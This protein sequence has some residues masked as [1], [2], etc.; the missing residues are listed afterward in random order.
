MRNPF[1]TI[2]KYADGW[3]IFNVFRRS[4]PVATLK[5]ITDGSRLLELMEQEEVMLDYELARQ[6]YARGI[7]I[8][9]QDVELYAIMKRVIEQAEGCDPSIL[10]EQAIAQMRQASFQ[11]IGTPCAVW[12]A[13][14]DR[15]ERDQEGEVVV[16]GIVTYENST[17]L[18][19]LLKNL[20]RDRVRSLLLCKVRNGNYIEI[21]PFYQVKQE[22]CMLCLIE[23]QEN[24]TIIGNKSY[25]SLSRHYYLTEYVK[26]LV[27]MFASY[28]IRLG[29]LHERKLLI[30]DHRI[31][32]TSVINPIFFDCSCM[33][34]TR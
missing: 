7:F 27:D 12:D 31:S 14:S 16:H 3:G 15:T 6:L 29:Q 23:T 33:N 1:Y 9:E 18:Y 4:K 26:V 20:N 21:G 19:D 34:H 28:S 17:E 32:L 24:Y 30:T 25:S 2:E 11:F 13:L 5:N 8:N 10:S 22:S